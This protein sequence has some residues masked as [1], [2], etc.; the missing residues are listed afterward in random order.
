M[1]QHHRYLKMVSLHDHIFHAAGNLGSVARTHITWSGPQPNLEAQPKVLLTLP[2]LLEGCQALHGVGHH[3]HLSSLHAAGARRQVLSL[4]PADAA[5]H[6][7][8]RSGTRVGLLPAGAAGGHG[9]Q[10]SGTRV[11]L[12]PAGA[13]EHGHICFLAY[14]GVMICSIPPDNRSRPSVWQLLGQLTSRDWVGSTL[15]HA[16]RLGWGLPQVMCVLAND[17]SA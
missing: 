14:A 9:C 6:G 7:C 17:N 8:Q 3:G 15:G 10:R 2:L 13:A 4:L 11:G 1:P 12:L 16:S 5:G